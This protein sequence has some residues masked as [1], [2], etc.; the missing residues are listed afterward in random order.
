MK[1][2][3]GESL[4][5]SWLRHV[6]GC[7]IVQAN[8]KPS[9][10]WPIRHEPGLAADFE[11]MREIAEQRL[12]FEIFK[13]SSFQQFMRQAEVDV[14]GL[15]FT[16]AGLAAIAVD[17]AFHENGVQY[18]DLKETV[19]RILKKMIRTAFVL[20]GYFDVHRAD[21]VFA[22]PKMHNA[23]HQALQG[24]WPELQSVLADCGSLSAARLQ[25]RI[26][27][28][29]DFVEQIIQPVLDRMD[30]VADT[31]ELFLRAQQLVRFCEVTPRQR[32]IHK[33]SAAAL[34]VT[35]GEPKIGEYVRQTMARLAQAGR[36]K[37][38]VIGKLLDARYCKKTFNL[39]LP[40]LK[41]IKPHFDLANQRMDERGYGRYWKDPLNTGD[42]QFLM[43]SQWFLWQRPAFDRWV[44]D[45]G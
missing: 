18:G 42:S 44:R 5:F 36:L 31:T 25:L 10:T 2:E 4:I 7:P 22:T 16:D 12:G 45:L 38:E 21:I 24:C 19:G 28:N 8:W 30:Q 37:P 34:P 35:D 13:R 1:I 17:S 6:R 29:G 43:C 33:N 26:V 20:E 15:G 27:T 39:G 14:L 23:V 9:P 41:A 40:F 3:I 32:R 11:K